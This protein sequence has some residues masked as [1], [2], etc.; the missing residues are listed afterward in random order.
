MSKILL[1]SLRN[2]SEWDSSREVNL[3]KICVTTFCRLA[4]SVVNKYRKFQFVEQIRVATIWLSYSFIGSYMFDY[5]YSLLTIMLSSVFITRHWFRYF[6]LHSMCAI[7]AGQGH[8][9]TIWFPANI[10]HTMLLSLIDLH[11]CVFTTLCPQGC[12]YCLVS[13]SLF[14]SR[15]F[16]TCRTKYCVHYLVSSST[17]T[18]RCVVYTTWFSFLC[19]HDC[20]STI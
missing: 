20:P 11:I 12:V 1:Y 2:S 13:T 7:L 5:L 9:F 3:F 8:E 15:L 14:P 10:E 6:V 16:S 18:T 17:V 19:L 4:T